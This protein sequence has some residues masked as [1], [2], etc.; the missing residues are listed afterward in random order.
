MRKGDTL[1]LWLTPP[2]LI[3][4][5]DPPLVFTKFWAFIKST[6]FTSPPIP[7]FSFRFCFYF[8]IFFFKIYNF[9][10]YWLNSLQQA[11]TKVER[12]RERENQKNH[13]NTIDGFRVAAFSR[14]RSLCFH[15]RVF[16]S[17]VFGFR[18]SARENKLVSA[19]SRKVL[20]FRVAASF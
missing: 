19:F 18:V 16:S 12:A 14:T 15:I 5:L 11:K 9:V 6:S 3:K 2:P 13:T 17:C 8:A 1:T 20:R 7:S 10:Y 4:I